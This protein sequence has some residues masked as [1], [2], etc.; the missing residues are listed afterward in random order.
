MRL[1][2]PVKRPY[3]IASCV[4]S[5]AVLFLFALIW[6]SN[7]NTLPAGVTFNGQ[8]V[9]GMP[10]DR[11]REMLKAYEQ[12]WFKQSVAFAAVEDIPS[13]TLTLR[14]LGLKTDIAA[15]IKDVD[16]LHDGSFWKRANIRWRMRNRSLVAHW[17]MD[18]S[19]LQQTI[20]ATWAGL[21]QK[22]PADA[23]RVITAADQ[24]EYIPGRAAYR[25]N[26]LQLEKQLSEKL[27]AVFPHQTEKP[28]LWNIKL[29]LRTIEPNVTLTSLK[30]QGIERKIGEFATRFSGSEEGRVHNIRATAQTVH[31]LLLKPGETFD[32]AKIVR[33]T[34]K[35]SGYRPAPV[36]FNGKIVPGIGGGICQVS[37]TLYNAALRSGLEIVERKN[38]SLPVA[39]VPLGQDATFSQGYINFKFRNNTGRHLLI[40]TLIESGAGEI[41]VKLFGG[42]PKNFTYDVESKIVA[43]IQ[44]P[45]KYVKNPALPPD[46]QKVLETG[47]QGC[48]VE[49]FRIKK[50]NNAVVRRELVSRDTY[51]AQP[52]VMARNSGNNEDGSDTPPPSPQPSPKKPILEDGLSGPV[53]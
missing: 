46:T 38:H 12:S 51:K 29:P 25:V 21:Q 9:G 44:P 14:Q 13:K 4:C 23:K 45:V 17:N 30:T 28:L 37:T 3:V 33:E 35:Q 47:K 49:T 41:T 8:P 19:V 26:E 40:R 24:V 39:Y 53:F 31:D 20:N 50:E 5:L 42:M 7:R 48:I 2:R 10:S 36:I 1:K 15:I 16:A 11:F 52:T 32:F 6:Y 27:S 34:E 43:V 22:Q 18:R